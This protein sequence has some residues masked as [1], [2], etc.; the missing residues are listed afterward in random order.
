M[1]PF[2]PVAVLF[3]LSPAAYAIETGSIRC[4]ALFSTL[5]RV[6]YAEH[7]VTQG[8]DRQDETEL[9]LEGETRSLIDGT[10]GIELEAQPSDT[11]RTLK[12]E[13]RAMRPLRPTPRT[14]KPLAVS[15]NRDAAVRLETTPGLQGLAT[16]LPSG[17]Q[18][19]RQG[20][21]PDETSAA[22]E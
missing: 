11:E 19:R 9:L 5:T 10:L 17:G 21:N 13:R 4:H 12:F 3:A 1:R 22:D 14:G 20:L 6:G 15:R 16:R 8:F 18:H 7:P 2:V